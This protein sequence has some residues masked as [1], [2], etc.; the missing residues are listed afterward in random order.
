MSIVNS[1]SR[2]EDEEAEALES[3]RPK[4]VIESHDHGN[5]SAD[6]VVVVRDNGIGIPS[7]H[8]KTVFAPLMRLW[9]PDQYEGTGLGLSICQKIADRHGGSIWCTSEK[10]QGSS[11]FVKFPQPVAN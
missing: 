2:E 11:F 6:H 5:G 9:V 4:I 10:G 7:N 1:V 3:D 8:L